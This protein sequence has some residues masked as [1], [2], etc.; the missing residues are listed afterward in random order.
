MR[1]TC[2]I[3]GKWSV[4][5]FVTRTITDSAVRAAHF[6]LSAPL[7]YRKYADTL[8]RLYAHY[9]TLKPP[10]VKSVWSALSINFP[11][12]AYCKMHLDRKNKAVG[13]CAI[14]AG[15]QFDH[16]KGEHLRP[17]RLG[18][19]LEFPANSVILIPSALL[20]HGNTP[21]Q[22][23]ERRFV[24]TM[25]TAGALFR[26]DDYAYQ[27]ESFLKE[28]HKELWAKLEVKNASNFEED[29]KLW[30]SIENLHRDRVAAK[31]I[32]DATSTRDPD[33]E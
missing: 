32:E 5:I 31:L 28:H 23:G 6:A 10:F 16:K 29:L 13:W 33:I 14:F 4:P 2:R 26:H 1:A 19:Q 18:L 20:I 17:P 21:I 3:L 8:D 9:P 27:T 12:R 22:P 11:P 30:S 24:I 25:Y 15:G 7:L